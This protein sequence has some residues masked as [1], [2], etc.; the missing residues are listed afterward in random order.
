VA[1]NQKRMKIRT[2]I[3][4][5]SVLAIAFSAV[6]GCSPQQ[7]TPDR[8]QMAITN[9]ADMY[10]NVGAIAMASTIRENPDIANDSGAGQVAAA[11]KWWLKKHPETA[12]LKAP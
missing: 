2:I 1:D 6:L 7:P 10:F 3:Q 12:Y 9:C 8:L 5:A 4:L 11:R